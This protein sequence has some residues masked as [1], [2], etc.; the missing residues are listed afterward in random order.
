MLSLFL[1]MTGFVGGHFLLSA[2]AVRSRLVS[3]WG[4][5]VF[6]V[7]YSLLSA[8]LLAWA[9]TAYRGA[10]AIL[11]WDLGS[12]G[13][14]IAI[15]LMPF[16]LM[17]AAIGLTVRNPTA[18]GGDRPSER[19]IPVKG[20]VTI[21]RHPFLWGAALWALTHLAANGD[22]ASLILFGGMAVLSM[23]GMA[24]IDAKR[25]AKLG[26]RWREFSRRT[27]AV[28]FTAALRN[29]T[30]VD[31]RGIGLWRP[32]LGLAIYG[33]IV[34]VHPWLFGVPVLPGG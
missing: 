7:A 22:A 33:I 1:A 23:G 24:A 31:W 20:I 19:P 25:A 14:W 4:E 15:V 5:P 26:E 3:R 11:L 10:P 29:G 9:V 28:P 32:A 12:A 2:P 16:A 18:V 6:L 30:P 21:T 34:A 27:S 8:L 17:L 13:R